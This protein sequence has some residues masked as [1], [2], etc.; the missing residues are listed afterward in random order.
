METIRERIFNCGIIPVVVIEDA[1]NA[2]PTA[3]ALKA[4]GV[5]V[6]EITMRTDAGLQAISI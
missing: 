5:D 2:V 4:G 1:K 3:N 6:I